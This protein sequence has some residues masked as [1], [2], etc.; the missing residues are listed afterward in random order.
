L[1]SSI[2]ATPESAKFQSAFARFKRLFHLP[3]EEKLVNCK[4]FYFGY[5]GM[6]LA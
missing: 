5:H 3:K 2:L 6:Q 1:L 4:S